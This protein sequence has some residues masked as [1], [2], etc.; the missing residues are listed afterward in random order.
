YYTCYF[1]AR[2]GSSGCQA[3]RLSADALDPL[4][5]D[6]LA[7]FYAKADTIL[8]EAITRAHDQ[9]H[10]DTAHHRQELDSV[11]Q[12]IRA[13]NAAIDKYLAAFETG[14]LDDTTAG[15]RLHALRTDIEQLRARH[16]ELEDQLNDAPAALPPADVERLR[17]HLAD[18]I[19][20]GTTVE[21]KATIEALIAE[22]KIT[23]E[24]LC[25]CSAYRHNRRATTRP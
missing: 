9:H 14:T 17:R 10:R 3:P 7:D 11:A 19:A 16:A 21:K 20:S 24:G 8:T 13:K 2:Y 12:Q 5:L 23:D 18:V 22:I 1:R 25:P 4:V 15:P 6:A